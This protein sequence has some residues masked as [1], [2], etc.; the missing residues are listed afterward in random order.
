MKKIRS[1]FTV[2]RAWKVALFVIMSVVAAVPAVRPVLAIDTE[3]YGGNDIIFYD[4]TCS[5]ASAAD[6]GAGLVDGDNIRKA[7][8]YFVQNH[9]LTA[10][11]SA[12]IVGNLIQESGVNPKSEQKG[13]PGRGIAQWSAGGRWEALKKWAGSKDIYLLRTQLDF[14]WYEMTNV[15]PWKLALK[16]SHDSQYPSLQDIKGNTKADAI[17][18]GHSFGKLYEAFGVSGSRDKYAGDV[19]TKYHSQAG[20]AASGATGEDTSGEGGDCS[21]ASETIGNCKGAPSGWV[22][23][24]NKVVESACAEW[25]KKVSEDASFNCDKAGNITKYAKSVGFGSCGLA[26]CGMFVGYNYK[27]AGMP[28]P[29]SAGVASVASVYSYFH[30]IGAFKSA[31][32]DPKPGS[33]VTYGTHHEGLVVGVSGKYV[34]TIEGNTGPDS[35][36]KVNTS[37]IDGVHMHHRTHPGGGQSGWGDFDVL[38]KKQAK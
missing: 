8:F 15:S 21:S 35:Q 10:A 23:V 6:S 1:F 12:G 18:A 5:N 11:Q 32:S 3:F 2:K 28:F 9:Q 31:S 29:A 30:K 4:P 7:F 33:V 19:W 34:T 16:G 17:K 20:G 25:N 13:G 14:I 22:Q 36:D 37:H 26:W 24:T 27:Q 38:S